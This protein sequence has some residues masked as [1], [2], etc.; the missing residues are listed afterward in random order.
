MSATVTTTLVYPKSDTATGSVNDYILKQELEDVGL[1][2]GVQEVTSIGTDVRIVLSGNASEADKTAVD[3]VIAAH[4]GDAFQEPPMKVY[5]E[6]LTSDDSGDEIEKADLEVGPLA[7]GNYIVGW[8]ME[9]ATTT[10]TGTSG[11]R[12]IL[13]ISKNG[14][15]AVER[16]QDSNGENQFKSFSG[17]LAL[18]VLDGESYSFTLL[19]ERIGASGNASRVQRARITLVRV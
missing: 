6:T 18:K 13:D 9:H 12:A 7:A 2:V 8:Y 4:Q 3:A 15:A 10:T 14:G 5:A 16:A 11:S 17:S 19:H 1:S